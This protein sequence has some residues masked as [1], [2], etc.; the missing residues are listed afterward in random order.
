MVPLGL[1]I[2][3]AEGPGRDDREVVAEIPFPEPPPVLR[4]LREVA[5]HVVEGLPALARRVPE[6]TPDLPDGP[7]PGGREGR[8]IPGE[9]HFFLR[10]KR[11]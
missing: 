3:A 7:D 11:I 10:S 9:H 2:L 4:G 6:N 8:T 5:L 1:H